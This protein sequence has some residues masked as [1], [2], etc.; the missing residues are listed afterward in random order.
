MARTRSDAAD[1]TEDVPCGSWQEWLFQPRRLFSVAALMASMV[2]GPWIVRQ[3]P[4]LTDRPEYQFAFQQIELDPPVE[5]PVPADLLQQVQRSRELP[6]RLLLLDP[7]L[8]RQLAEA[9]SG[10]PW[11]ASVTAVEVLPSRTV[12]VSVNYRRP[13]ALIRVPMGVQAIDHESVLLPPG[14]IDAAL[15]A[16]TLPIVGVTSTPQGPAGTG[17]GDP[18]VSAAAQLADFLGP[19]WK[20]LQLSAVQVLPAQ[21]RETTENDRSPSTNPGAVP[22]ESQAETSYRSAESPPARTES[23]P[24]SL[25][26]DDRPSSASSAALDLQPQFVL[27]TSGGS[28]IYWGRGPQAQYPGEIPASQKLARL[29]RYLAQFGSFDQPQGPYE[30]DIRHWQEIS[31]K[32][33]ATRPMPAAAIAGRPKD[34]NPARGSSASVSGHRGPPTSAPLQVDRPRFVRPR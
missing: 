24:H 3:L 11:I 31:R 29:E 4:D 30:I 23:T 27:L 33:L 19:R 28:R 17:W 16:R 13:V 14:D 26:T 18:T 25:A 20:T 5:A 21:D 10:H 7:G 2:L 8:P 15:L 32:Q 9:F 6:D 1:N 12:R 34:R 22:S